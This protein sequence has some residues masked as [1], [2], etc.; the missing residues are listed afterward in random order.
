[1]VPLYGL[2]DNAGGLHLMP[3]SIGT[4]LSAAGVLYVLCQYRMYKFA[5]GRLGRRKTMLLGTAVFGP[6]SLLVP[7]ALLI[8]GDEAESNHVLGW[9]RFFYLGF[10]IGLNR[11]FAR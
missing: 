2:A 8:P 9:P 1:M 6:L 4:F 3:K 7:C 5:I 10:V 11:A